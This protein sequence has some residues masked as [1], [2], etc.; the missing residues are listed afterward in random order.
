MR[1]M[2]IAQFD[3]SNMRRLLVEFPGQVEDAVRIGKKSPAPYASASIN[4]IV[5][6]GL[7]G[8]AIGGDLLRSYLQEE[9][10]IPFFVNRHYFLPAFVGK[11]SL[12]IVSSYSGNT[13]ET[14]ASHK[15][16]TKR[17][18]KV[19]C[20]SSNGET[21]RLARKYHQPL[22]TIPKGFPPRVALGY[23]FFPVLVALTKMKLIKTRD[24]DIR[25]TVSL[26]K[27]KS[28]LYSSPDLKKNKAFKLAQKLYGKVPIVYSAADKFDIV[29]LRWRGQFAENAKVLAFGHVL[30]EMNHNELVGWKVLKR[31]MKNMVAIFLRD[32][33]DHARVQRRM[34]IT[35]E[36]VGEYANEVVEMYSEGTSLMAR[37]FSLIYLGDWTS[38]YLAILNGIDPTPV[39]VIDYLKNELAKV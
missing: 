14:V 2:D 16:A 22:I 15:E 27:E 10:H 24:K 6:T 7:G 9:L 12:V 34:A 11:N 20:I 31:Q 21:E 30:P 1:E 8:S 37:I 4:N 36:I 25:E 29:N 18:A 3:K 13:E 32:E 28:K 26:L 5:V 38:Y 17:D 19:L 23:S 33:S 35:M 39:R